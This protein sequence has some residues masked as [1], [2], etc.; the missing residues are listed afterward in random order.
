MAVII[1]AHV[2]REHYEKYEEDIKQ[3]RER[4]KFLKPFILENHIEE[5]KND[6]FSYLY[7]KIWKPTNFVEATKDTGA[8]NGIRPWGMALQ[9]PDDI[10]TVPHF[11]FYTYDVSFYEWERVHR[12]LPFIDILKNDE[13]IIN[14]EVLSRNQYLN[15]GE[16]ASW[17]FLYSWK[18]KEK[19]VDMI[20]IVSYTRLKNTNKIVVF[21]YDNLDL[22]FNGNSRYA[23]ELFRLSC[24]GESAGGIIFATLTD[25]YEPYFQD[26]FYLE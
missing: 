13:V 8:V 21:V 12:R 15:N 18:I 3:I 14:N 7:P 5:F 23:D 4:F 24:I 2:Q 10:T 16:I 22:E 25:A 17:E 20:S 9:L 11:A 1:D 26:K 6:T 19:N